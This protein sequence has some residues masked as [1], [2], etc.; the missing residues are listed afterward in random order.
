MDGDGMGLR[1][2]AYYEQTLKGNLGLQLMSLVSSECESTKP[3][4]PNGGFLRHDCDAP[5]PPSVP[6]DFVRNGWINHRDNKMV[7]MLP[8]NHGYSILS[9]PHGVHSLPMLQQLA[10]PPEDGKAVAVIENELP[11]VKEAPLRKR[12][13]PQ[14]RPCKAPRIK[15]S[16]KVPAPNDE[17]TG[18]SGDR[19]RSTKKSTDIVIN[20]FDLDISSLPTPVC[21]CTGSRR[22]CYKWGVGG[23]QSACC[24][25]NI[26][27]H[28]LPMSTKKRGAR[29]AG[30]KMS[31]GAF[32]K[33]LEKLTGEGYNLS[34]PI[35]LKN[36]WAKHGTNKFVTIR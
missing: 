23:W 20:G 14:P 31:L 24:T 19:A 33:V 36:H 2:W 26:S 11:S 21:S 4:L 7:H 8:F 15:K 30:R 9:E 35:D 32:K 18:H 5:P 17:S 12:S 25:T 27:M 3:L 6:M 34:N 29:I 16:K 1:G 22:Q 10:P 28:P 13:Q